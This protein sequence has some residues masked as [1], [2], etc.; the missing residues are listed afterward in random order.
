M[1][2]KIT[3]PKWK[4]AVICLKGLD[5]IKTPEVN[6]ERGYC[7]QLFP[8]IVCGAISTIMLRRYIMQTGDHNARCSTKPTGDTFWPHNCYDIAAEKCKKI[9]KSGRFYK[10]EVDRE[11]LALH[12]P[13]L[14]LNYM[15]LKSSTEKSG[16]KALNAPITTRVL[17][18]LI[19][20]IAEQRV[21]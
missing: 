5:Y 20:T 1:H 12:R 13:E 16:E 10:K 4:G 21:A 3:P 14:K 17:L 15:R 6:S 11:R 18:S 8:Q 9:Q 19:Y 2:K 7:P